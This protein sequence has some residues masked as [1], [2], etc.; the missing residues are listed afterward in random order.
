L[1]QKKT[2]SFRFR[3]WKLKFNFTTIQFSAKFYNRGENFNPFWPL[4]NFDYGFDWSI[5]VNQVD[6]GFEWWKPRSRRFDL[7]LSW[8]Q[9]SMLSDYRLN[10]LD[11]TF[12]NKNQTSIKT[13]LNCVQITA[14]IA[15]IRGA[16]F[17]FKWFYDYNYNLGHTR[18]C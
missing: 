9:F 16:W 10:K 17:L 13:V 7:S 4:A 1:S 5:S 15:P 8:F 3:G 11:F 14:L 6:F 18:T 12:F 2:T